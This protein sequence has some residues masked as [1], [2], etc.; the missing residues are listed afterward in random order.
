MLATA[1][2]PTGTIRSTPIP[3]AAIF[4]TIKDLPDCLLSTEM[5]IPSKICCRVLSPSATI[6]DTFT[7]SPT[8]MDWSLYVKYF[9]IE[10][11]TLTSVQISNYIKRGRMLQSR[12]HGSPKA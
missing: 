12:D 11:N 6:N 4:R 10:G 5:M 3:P 9:A 1:G 7:V 2:E 8:E